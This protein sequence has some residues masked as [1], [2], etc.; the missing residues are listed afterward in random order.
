MGVTGYII[1]GV[2]A[3]F[4]GLIIVNYYRMKNMP[5]GKTSD[6]IANLNA[7]NFKTAITKY[8]LILVD[9]WAPWCGPCKMMNPI[10]SEVAEKSDDYKIAKVNVDNNQPLAKKN[11]VRNIPTMILFRDGQEVKRYVG[12]KSKKVLVK[13]LESFVG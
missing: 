5:E 10:L 8:N 7:K 6:K 9:F 2:I 11:K 13:D 12:A 3:A 1:I 4:F